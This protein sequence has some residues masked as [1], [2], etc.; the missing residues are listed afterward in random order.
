VTHRPPENWKDGRGPLNGAG[1][2]RGGLATPGHSDCEDASPDPSSGGVGGAPT[3]SVSLARTPELLTKPGLDRN[4]SE[5]SGEGLKAGNLARSPSAASVRPNF[6]N[7]EVASVAPDANASQR[8]RGGTLVVCPTT[9]L[10][11]WLQEFKDKVAAGAGLSA[12]IYHGSSRVQDERQL[13]RYDLVITTYSILAQQRQRAADPLFCL[14]WFRVILDEAQLIKNSRT[15]VCQA[16]LALHAEYRWCLSGTPVQNSIDEL[17]VRPASAPPPGVPP[18]ASAPPP[19]RGPATPPAPHARPPAGAPPQSFFAF[20]H[21]EPYSDPAKFKLMVKDPISEDQATGM[22]RLATILRGVVMRRTKAT[23]INGKPIVPLPP[24]LLEKVYCEPSREEKERFQAIMEA[25][26]KEVQGHLQGGSKAYVNML[27]LM[28]RLRQC[29]NHPWLAN[30]PAHLRRSKGAD[31]GAQAEVKA[32]RRLGEPERDRMARVLRGGLSQCACCSDMPEDARVGRCSHVFC[33]QC[34]ATSLGGVNGSDASFECPLCGTPL[35]PSDLFSITSLAAAGA[36]VDFS[37]PAAGAGAGAGAGGEDGK[38]AAPGAPTC[39]GG[40]PHFEP[41]AKIRELMG[42]VKRIH[43]ENMGGAAADRAAGEAAGG[44]SGGRGAPAGGAARPVPRAK[45][46]GRLAGAMRKLP[47]PP[48]AAGAA[49]D[50]AAGGGEGARQ[51]SKAIVF[52]QWTTM[53]DLVEIPLRRAGVSYRRLDG[54]MSVA[55]R[56]RA[57]K[58]FR[59]CPGVEVMLMS[60]KAA[61]LGLN[62]TCAN[63]VVLLDPWFNPTVEEQAIDRAHRIGQQRPVHVTRLVVKGSVEEKIVKLQERKVDLAKAA[64]EGTEAMAADGC[65]GADGAPSLDDLKF[66]FDIDTAV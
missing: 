18:P 14:Q 60:L 27:L 55:A 33:Q 48:P 8:R 56:E 44:P 26:K 11:Q 46:A 1:G 42:I 28:L 12:Y 3:R 16:A 34:A 29:C 52:S 57:L 49:L 13:A 54:T 24:R 7:A 59:T 2:N 51:V 20:L 6:A 50:A 65:S 53:L 41:S 38:A 37:P 39:A 66:L 45:S 35:R 31:A 61:A 10:Q 9:V 64:L 63:H 43:A 22:K 4:A 62:L 17:Q 40:L 32:A 58:D 25:S 5:E 36:N 15:L 23:Q 47:P 30:P 21:F 19:P